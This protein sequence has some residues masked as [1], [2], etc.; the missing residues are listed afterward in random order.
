MLAVLGH[1]DVR[2]RAALSG[3]PCDTVRNADHARGMGTSLRAGV[4]RAAEEAADAVVIVLGDMPLV[5]AEAVAAVI[6]RYRAT[7]APLVLSVYGAVAAPPTLYDRGLFGEL[8][9]I[10]DEDGGRAVTR[11]HRPEAEVVS[12]PAAARADLD[13]PADYDAARSGDFKGRGRRPGGA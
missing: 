10:G 13:T 8:L 2:V 5:G 3:L 1:D 7:R 4:R 9:A 11:H 6:G 12:W